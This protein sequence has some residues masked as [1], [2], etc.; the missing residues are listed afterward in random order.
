MDWSRIADEVEMQ[1]NSFF[2][3]TFRRRYD[4][5]QSLPP[6]SLEQVW[7]ADERQAA[8][9]REQEKLEGTILNNSPF[10]SVGLA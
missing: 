4:D 1:T 7:N 10:F 2:Q 9:R 5:V 8:A 6:V 3:D